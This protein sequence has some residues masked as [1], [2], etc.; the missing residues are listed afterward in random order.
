MI[1]SRIKISIVTGVLLMFLTGMAHAAPFAEQIH[2]VQPDGTAIDL[3]GQGDE[4]YADFETMDGYTVVFDSA[5]KAYCYARL[6]ADENQLES[7]GQLVGK[8]NPQTL[9]LP[10]HLR[11]RPAAMQKIAR[12]NFLRWDEVS[13]STERW[14]EMKAAW[15][16]AEASAAGEVVMAPPNFTTTGTKVGLTLL[17]DFD[18]D[19]ATIPQ[20][21]IVK[22][23]NADSYT[24]YGN[25]GSVKQ[26]FLDNSKNLLTY[27]NVVTV[28]IRIPNSKHPQEL[29]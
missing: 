1:T 12:E 27:S 26:Y 16:A 18:D 2:F 7:T 22:F 25:N 15:R 17:I 20:A 21:E 13:G 10:K 6:S 23:C 29:V 19:P 8:I 3:W 24:N 9:G 11:I 4:F 5:R 14:N 28:Y